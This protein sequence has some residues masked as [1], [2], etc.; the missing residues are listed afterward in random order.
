MTRPSKSDPIAQ[1]FPLGVAKPAVRA[2][3]AAGYT[4]LDQL[5]KAREA[6]IAGLHGM[7]PKAL[8]ILREA[9]KERGKSFISD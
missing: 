7:G 4:S 9:L 5:T 8:G 2:L 3:V 6:D 1:P